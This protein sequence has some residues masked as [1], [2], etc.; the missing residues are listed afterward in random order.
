[1]YRKL[2]LG[3]F[4]IFIVALFT[5]PL[6]AQTD[7][8]PCREEGLVVRN[9][10]MLDL[11]Y[12]KKDSDCFIWKRDKLF[13]IKPKDTIYI[14]SDSICK[15]QYCKDNPTYNIYKSFDTDGNCRVKIL[16]NC[17]LSDM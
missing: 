8:D 3:V 9:M 6:L 13:V 14:F 2:Y 11:W 5:V 15:T 7:E 10:T 1:M 12:K 17:T 16:S 4:T